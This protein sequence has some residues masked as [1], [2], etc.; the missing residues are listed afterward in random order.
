MMELSK[1]N[2]D[3]YKFIWCETSFMWI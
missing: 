1:D 2:G 3:L